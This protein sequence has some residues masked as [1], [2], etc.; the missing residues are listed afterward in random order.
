MVFYRVRIVSRLARQ[1]AVIFIGIV[2]MLWG[3]SDFCC[4]K[5]FSS[6][7]EEQ[8]SSVFTVFASGRDRTA[9]GLRASFTI[10][11]AIVMGVLLM[12]LSMLIQYAYTEHDKVIGAMILEETL[13][14]ARRDSKREDAEQYYESIGEQMG[15]S[16]LWFDEYEMEISI[17]TTGITGKAVSD[18]WKKEIELDLFR[19]SDFLRKKEMLQGIWNNGDKDDGEDR[20][21]EGN[22]SELHG[23]PIRDRSE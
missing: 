10:E 15:T 8:D 23:D 18:D 11:A 2:S 21:Q 13:I 20:I 19:P 14:R 7:K 3:E 5:L 16:Q 12:S 1:C 17:G 4:P 22:E 9:D 6:S